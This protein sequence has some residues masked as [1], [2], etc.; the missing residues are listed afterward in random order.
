MYRIAMVSGALTTIAAGTSTAG[1]L[2][3]MRNAS[4]TMKI[5]VRKIRLRWNQTVAFAAAQEMGLAIFRLPSWIIAGSGGVAATMTSSNKKDTLNGNSAVNDLRIA[6]TAA[7]AAGTNS[8]ENQPLGAQYWWAAGI[9]NDGVFE[10][11]FEGDPTTGQL[12]TLGLNEGICVRNE[13]LM[14]AGGVGRLV[15]EIDWNEAT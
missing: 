9:G 8:I 13:I 3:Y 10:S 4:S 5:I 6:N 2:V 12:V 7:L 1:H 14:G 15:C 11:T